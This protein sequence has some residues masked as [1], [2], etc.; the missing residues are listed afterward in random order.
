M[1]RLFNGKQT[2]FQILLI[3][4]Q[5]RLP[6]DNKAIDDAMEV[7]LTKCLQQL[8]KSNPNLLLTAAE[9][10][11]VERDIKYVPALSLAL[12]SIVSNAVGPARDPQLKQQILSWRTQGGPSNNNNHN[13][14]EVSS[15]QDQ[16]TQETGST[17]PH[18]E[19]EVEQ[20]GRSIEERLRLVLSKPEEKGKKNKA[21]KKARE[22][23]VQEETEGETSEVSSIDDLASLG[24]DWSILDDLNGQSTNRSETKSK[25]NI[26][27]DDNSSAASQNLLED[28]PE[29]NITPKTNKRAEIVSPEDDNGFYTDW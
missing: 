17:E 28:L 29:S 25:K 18:E 12:A 21:S 16:E 13:A 5:G 24:V 11:R 22:E 2:T 20:M 4:L 6:A 15:R 1:F 3:T 10:R 9:L 19:S 7:G 23:I 8:Q 26:P 27:L 14:A